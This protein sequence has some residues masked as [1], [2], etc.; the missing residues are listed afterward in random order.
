MCSN[1][2]GGSTEVTSGAPMHE[3]PLVA[4]RLC[5]PSP[6]K[7]ITLPGVFWHFGQVPEAALAMVGL[8]ERWERLR[9]AGALQKVA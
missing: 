4:T 8:E 5:H 1:T 2:S 6:A 9:R 3:V 7:A